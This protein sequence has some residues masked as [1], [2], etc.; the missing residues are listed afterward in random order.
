LLTFWKREQLEKRKKEK[1][2]VELGEKNKKTNHLNMPGQ[3]NHGQQQQA[4]QRRKQSEGNEL[5]ISNNEDEYLEQE[6]CSS[7]DES[8]S[9]KSSCSSDQEKCS[10]SCCQS[11]WKVAAACFLAYG[12]W[13]YWSCSKP[14][15]PNNCTSGRYYNNGVAQSS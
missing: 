12:A 9:T 10:S 4:R 3:K 14:I 8:S 15:C 11:K 7:D 6:D 13:K 5:Q 1:I 2:S